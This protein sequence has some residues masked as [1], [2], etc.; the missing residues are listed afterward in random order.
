MKRLLI[1][2]FIGL[3]E[4][5]KLPRLLKAAMDGDL[6]GTTRFLSQ[7][8][9]IDQFIQCTNQ[10]GDTLLF[11]NALYLAA[12][13]GHIDVCKFLINHGIDLS[14]RTYLPRTREVFSA[15]SI[16]LTNFHFKLW[17]YL[18]SVEANYNRNMAVGDSCTNTLTQHLL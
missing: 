7:G 9:D 17:N 13:N 12:Q 1:Y 5:P 3:M 18:R 4:V 16:A 8:D 15:S 10:N 14:I 11:I 2:T 6:E